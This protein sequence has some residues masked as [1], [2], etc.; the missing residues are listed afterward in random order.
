MIRLK[1]GARFLGMRADLAVARQLAES[2]HYAVGVSEA[3]VTSITDEA[4][5][6][7]PASRHRLGA[8][9]DIR[10]PDIH[11]TLPATSNISDLVDAIADELGA[12]ALVILEDD[13]IHI[14]LQ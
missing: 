3:W 11:G 4:A 8:A 1:P 10:R 9:V 5:R 2:A 6:R 13:H 14:Q 7:A 12:E